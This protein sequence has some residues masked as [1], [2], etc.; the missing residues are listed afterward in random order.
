ME[1]VELHINLYTLSTEY[2]LCTYLPS[3][4]NKKSKTESKC[5]KPISLCF[6]GAKGARHGSSSV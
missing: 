2:I 3:K 6:K 4:Q 5:R 1:V